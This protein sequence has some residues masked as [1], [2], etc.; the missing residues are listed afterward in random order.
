ME[1]ITFGVK[2][3]HVTF[4]VSPGGNEKSV[5]PGCYELN[6]WEVLQTVLLDRILLRPVR[7]SLESAFAEILRV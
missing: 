3:I 4:P 2:I 5:P 1:L 7:S 6:C